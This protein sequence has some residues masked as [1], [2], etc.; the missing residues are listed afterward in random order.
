MTAQF[1]ELYS[2]VAWDHVSRP[3]ND[4]FGGARATDDGVK[5]AAT[6]SMRTLTGIAGTSA[7]SMILPPLIVPGARWCG[8][9]VADYKWP[10]K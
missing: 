8:A 9:M 3:G 6:D 7:T 4:F 5:A 2:M 1:C 10:T